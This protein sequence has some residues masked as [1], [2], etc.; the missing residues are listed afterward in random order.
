[1]CRLIPKIIS[2][3]GYLLIISADAFASSQM[4]LELSCNIV[5]DHYSG[6]DTTTSRDVTLSNYKHKPGGMIKV[7][8]SGDFEFWVM[9]HSVQKIN[10]QTLI[11]NFQVA[12][13]E[14]KSQLFMH[15]L[16][17]S[18]F[19]PGQ[20][21][22]HARISLISYHPDQSIETGELLFECRHFEPPIG[23]P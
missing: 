12:I 19:S 23:E 9:T 2:L 7:S 20:S 16:S 3:V 8:E 21:P 10:N 14:K 17:D 11:N 4:N 1:M 13:K 5:F 22:H 18:V 15:A 6:I